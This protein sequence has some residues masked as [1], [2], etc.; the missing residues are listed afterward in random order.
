M[1]IRPLTFFD[2]SWVIEELGQHTLVHDLKR[3]ELY[4]PVQ[5]S[6]L[7]NTCMK[8]GKS[9]VAEENG[10]RLGVIGG[11]EHGHVFN[12]EFSVF[13]VVFWFVEEESRG[14]SAAWRLLKTVID[15][16]KTNELE[17]ALAVQT[18]SLKHHSILTKLG[19]TEG[20]R[21]FRMR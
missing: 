4:N 1:R 15:Y 5:L 13:T 12:P 20:E 11:V 18:Y 3:P 7:F 16:S 17:L 9:W 8:M 19:F 10:K 2:K 6:N 21:T 14:S